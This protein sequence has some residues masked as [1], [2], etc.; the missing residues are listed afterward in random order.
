MKKLLS[1]VAFIAGALLASA[2]SASA[3][4]PPDRDYLVYALSEAADKITL[5]RFGPNGARI[6]RE[7]ATGVS[8]HRRRPRRLQPGGHERWAVDRYQ[9][10]WPVGF[11]LRFEIGQG[12][13]SPTD[14]APGRS[15]RGR[16][17]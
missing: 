15:R 14:E 6:E 9:Q 5:I 2:P 7:I 13:G 11:G 16:V 8:A 12:T 1:S 4:K 3:Q 10:T 17:A